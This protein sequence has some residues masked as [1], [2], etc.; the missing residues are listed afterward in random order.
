MNFRSAYIKLTLVYVAILML[1]SIGFSSI[2]YNLSAAEL[3]RG[4]GDQARIFRN[5]TPTVT[6]PAD[7][8]VG[9]NPPED[10]TFSQQTIFN[11]R[12]KN[13]QRNLI[14]F[15][16]LIMI[17][18]SVASYFLARLT[19][20]PIEET[21]DAQNRFAADA[22]HELRTPLTAM[23]TEI[24]VGLRD[25]KISVEEARQLLSSNL[26]EIG[27]LE[28]LS[29]GLLELAKYD[30]KLKSDVHKIDLTEIITEAYERVE[31]IA[32][33]KEIAF[34]NNFSDVVVFGNK[35]SLVELFAIL[36][37][38][39]IKYSP[40][41][42][43]I[44]IKTTKDKKYGIITITD[45]GNG[46]KATD[47]PHIFK[48]FYRADQSRSKNKADGYGLGLAIAKS[49]VDIHKGKINAQ[50]TPN[51]GTEFTVKLK[52]AKSRAR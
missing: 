40:A 33:A 52:L 42:S 23:R 12:N 46:I 25:N 9:N 35:Q 21:M 10:I 30:S 15:N 3:D 14:Y 22:S 27:K 37:D 36:L 39:A 29:N 26:E 34:N 19:M 43:T 6:D 17:L 24:E 18:S 50:S 7:P 51:K 47:L 44:T 16:I 32:N 8:A 41:K 28:A 45:K 31:K 38:N 49:I 2:I 4:L 1:V 5:Y 11:A 20:K 48:R 13:L